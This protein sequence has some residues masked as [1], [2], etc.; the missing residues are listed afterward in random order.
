MNSGKDA[1]PGLVPRPVNLLNWQGQACKYKG[2][3]PFIFSKNSASFQAIAPT[4]YLAAHAATVGAVFHPDSFAKDLGATTT[5]ALADLQFS[6]PLAASKRP[7]GD[8]FCIRL[9]NLREAS[10]HANWTMKSRKL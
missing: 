8:R 1:R 9:E 6:E 4:A 3:A 7:E 2:G 5:T 10:G